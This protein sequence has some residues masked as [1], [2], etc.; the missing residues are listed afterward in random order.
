MAQ[1]LAEQCPAQWTTLRSNGKLALSQGRALLAKLGRNQR[2]LEHGEWRRA[3][4]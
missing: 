2:D 3:R 1:G 4:C